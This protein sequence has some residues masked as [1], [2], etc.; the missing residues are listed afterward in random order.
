MKQQVIS[1]KKIIIVEDEK[2]ILDL[3]TL[4]LGNEGFE[5]VSFTSS[6]GVME[7]I[8]NNAVSL[9]VLDV[10]LPG[11]DGFTI[12]REIREKWFFPVIMLTAKIEE[13]Q[14]LKHS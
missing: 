1:D 9:A 5:V 4:Y 2:E 12:L 3:L 7:Y 14:G 13:L 6:E 8:S 10:M 11:T